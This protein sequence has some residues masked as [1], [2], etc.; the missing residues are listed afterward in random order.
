MTP[1]LCCVV[2]QKEALE[3]LPWI[4]QRLERRPLAPARAAL[5]APASIPAAPAR[6][7]DP[8][9]PA[10]DPAAFRVEARHVA[11]FA[12]IGQCSAQ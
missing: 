4:D 9:G 7:D 2:V 3:D 11:A 1:L 10:A 6:I 12:N 5:M 8:P